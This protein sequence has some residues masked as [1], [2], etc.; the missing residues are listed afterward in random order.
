V[1]TAGQSPP[2]GA[3][4]PE[5]APE[6]RDRGRLTHHLRIMQRRDFIH[7]PGLT[8]L[9]TAAAAASEGFT[10]TWHDA[11]RDRSLPVRLRLPAGDGPAPTIL[12]SHG[13]GG[14]RD[15]LGYLGRA[16]AEAGFIAVYLQ[17]P[18]TDS[19]LWQGRA[20]AFGAMA[21]AIADPRQALARLQDG[22]FALDELVQRNAAPGPLRGRVDL[23]RLG[24]AGHSYG[25]WTV[26]HL[27]GQVA[28]GR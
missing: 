25:A 21:A 1:R 24:I 22:V 17:H 15:G 14:S 2:H 19:A 7:L 5:Q 28:A 3:E 10:E 12:L 9:G 13:L 26:Q 11:A 16:L 4:V 23:G 18:G 8:A 20:D 27:L 6:K